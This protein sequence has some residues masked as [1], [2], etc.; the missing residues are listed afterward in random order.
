M[1]PKID[2]VEQN[3][4]GIKNTS[5]AIINPATEEKLDD[6]ITRT[7]EVQATPTTN[8]TLGRLKS[9]E[10]KLDIL[11]TT[12]NAIQTAQTDASQK[13]QISDS[14]GNA[15]VPILRDNGSY[16]LPVEVENTHHKIWNHYFNLETAVSTTLN[17][18]VAVNAKTLIFTDA[19]LFN[20]GDK[21]D[22]H[23]GLNH[24]HMYREIISI[25]TNTVTID[26]GVDV[27]LASGSQI[28]QTSF[29]MA[30]D[31]SATPQ[32]YTMKPR[33][34]EKV[35]CTRLLLQIVDGTTMDDT[36]F[37]GAPAL[38]DGVHIRKN[39]N[40]GASYETLAIWKAN[41]EMKEDMY[42]INYTTKAGGGNHGLNGRW[43][44]AK[45]GAVVNLDAAN[46]EFLEC[47]IQ[48]NLTLLIDFQI[49]VQGHFE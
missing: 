9:I 44:F 29:N 26:S 2:G 25:V 3:I 17:G 20:V 45:S 38:T 19:S 10:D 1:I 39:I 5:D 36:K 12:A 11:E 43:T 40:N 23:S 32:I 18:A 8:T 13:T 47:V 31:G 27:A 34:T 15:V 28:D 22:I 24:I 42:D 16:V 14:S 41:K 4:V 7:G 46:N 30:V 6:L 33:G 21:I 37:G 35:D 49:K 48:D